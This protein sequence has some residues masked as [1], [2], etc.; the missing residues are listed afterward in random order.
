[1]LNNKNRHILIAT[2]QDILEQ[3]I[4]DWEKGANNRVVKIIRASNNRCETKERVF[5]EF[6]AALQFGTYFGWNWDAYEECLCDFFINPDIDYKLLITNADYILTQF[7]KDLVI[8]LDILKCI[9]EYWQARETLRFQIIL[10]TEPSKS[11][12]LREQS[13]AYGFVFLQNE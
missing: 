2:A 6:A 4:K 3:S 9:D 10:H 1:M 12:L 7:P 5:Q 8:F 13:E 11:T